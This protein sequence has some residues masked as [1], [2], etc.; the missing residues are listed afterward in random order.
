MK[1][2]L[3]TGANGYIGK[4][5]YYFLKKKFQVIGIDKDKSTEKKILKCNI[6]DKKKLDKIFRREKPE[7]VIHLAAQSLVDETINK[8]KYY[9]NNDR[10]TKSLLEIIKKI[11]LKKL[12]FLALL[13]SIN[14][15]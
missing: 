13:Q 6:L 10:G 15:V 12:Y 5:L 3:I 4:C 7:V 8:K 2:V 14:K 9:D 11:T 1:K